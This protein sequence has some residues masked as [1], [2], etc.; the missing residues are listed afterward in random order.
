MLYNLRKGV[1]TI[2]KDSSNIETILSLLLLVLLSICIFTLISTGNTTEQRILQQN[3]V[4][5]NARIAEAYISNKLKQNDIS[6]KITVKQNPFTGQNA[7]VIINGTKE[8]KTNTWVYFNNGYLLESTTLDNMPPND[9]TS[10]KIA[11][12]DGFSIVKENQKVVTE[13]SYFYNNDPHTVKQI[14]VLRSQ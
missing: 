6:N 8:S 5:A 10:I 9:K 14:I 1:N 7:L 3:E 11:K 4:K 13:F 12:L 2:N